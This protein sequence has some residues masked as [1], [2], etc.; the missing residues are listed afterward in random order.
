MLTKSQKL[1]APQKYIPERRNNQS[2]KNDRRE[3]RNGRCPRKA[4]F[5]NP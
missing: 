2:M 5:T 4:L 1:K 3:E